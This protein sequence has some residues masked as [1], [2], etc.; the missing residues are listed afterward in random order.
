MKSAIAIITYN[1]LGALQ[2][3]LKGLT[4]HCA[5]Y[6][7]AI[8]EDCGQRDGTE[9]WLKGP[10]PRLIQ[11]RPE[12]LAEEYD[13]KHLAPHAQVFLGTTNLGV[14]GNSNRALRWFAGTDCEH[15]CL[16]ND[17]LHVLGDFVNFYKS[18]HQDLGVGL[19]CFCDFTHNSYRWMTVNSRGYRVKLL[20]RMTGIMLSLTREVL[21]KIG[22]FDVRFG[23]FGEEHC[24]YTVR[25]RFSG[26]VNLD[27]Q[28]QNCLDLEFPQSPLLKHQEVETSVIGPERAARDQE[29]YQIMNYI[30]KRYGQEPLYRPFY[31]R[32]PGPVGGQGGLGTPFDKLK[33]Y[34]LVDVPA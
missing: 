16:L 25:A 27:G 18:G 17:D 6:P 11:A 32:L 19:F 4:E 31:L 20:P 28:P 9:T 23:K 22:Y 29:A 21:D 3:T 8:F 15:L 12:I 10:Q 24:D 33:H 14:S 13:A 5:Q 26:F 1:R 34:Q 30:S 2:E 7:L